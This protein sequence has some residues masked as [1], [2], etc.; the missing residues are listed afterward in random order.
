[1]SSIF[2]SVPKDIKD[3]T[4]GPK[5][6]E[7]VYQITTQVQSQ[8]AK[9][10]SLTQQL[11]VLATTP[12]VFDPTKL[13]TS[14]LQELA[15]LL[16]PELQSTGSAS[17][18]VEQSLGQLAEPQLP[19]VQ[20]FPTAPPVTDPTAQDGVLVLVGSTPTTALL[21]RWSAINAQGNNV[22]PPVLTQVLTDTTPPFT[23]PIAGLLNS[24][25]ATANSNSTSFQTM[26]TVTVPFPTAGTTVSFTAFGTVSIQVGQTLNPLIQMQFGPFLDLNW[27]MFSSP[28]SGPNNAIWFMKGIFIVSSTGIEGS[29]VLTVG[30]PAFFVS[31]PYSIGTSIITVAGE[32]GITPAGNLPMS[33]A[34]QFTSQPSSAP[35]NSATSTVIAGYTLT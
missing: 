2:L 24:V 26:Q 18:S 30:A 12:P 20:Y 11:N 17:V 32:T 10:R 35:F 34:I 19:G 14:Q 3:K 13:S 22:D 5:V 21:Y 25:P 7:A 6:A 9:V 27:A 4:F 15:K 23:S 33:T 16:K 28:I 31:T 1:M 29:G 8:Q